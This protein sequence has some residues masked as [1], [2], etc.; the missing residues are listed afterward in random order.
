[1]HLSKNRSTSKKQKITL[2]DQVE[3][4]QVG[5]KKADVKM[6]PWIPFVRALPTRL[7]TKRAF[8]ALIGAML[9]ILPPFRR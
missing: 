6:M 9:P 1:M 4:F 7:E 8:K 3:S 2:F 5:D